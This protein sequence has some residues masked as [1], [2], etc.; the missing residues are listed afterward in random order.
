[1]TALCAIYALSAKRFGKDQS[2]EDDKG[3]GNA[4]D[5]EGDYVRLAQR[6]SAVACISGCQDHAGPDAGLFG[7][8]PCDSSRTIFRL[9]RFSLFV[10]RF[11]ISCRRPDRRRYGGVHYGRNASWKLKTWLKG[12]PLAGAWPMGYN[13]RQMP[14]GD[15]SIRGE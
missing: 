8:M 3:H 5:D 10:R 9:Y 13:G 7:G 11:S 14:V 2:Q 1:M 15:N 4:A 6:E 12:S